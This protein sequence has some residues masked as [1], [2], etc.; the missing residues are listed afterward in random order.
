LLLIPSA[1][2][3]EEQNI[4]INPLHPNSRTITATKQ[5]RSDFD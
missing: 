4:L 3:P 5:R 2:V 1:V